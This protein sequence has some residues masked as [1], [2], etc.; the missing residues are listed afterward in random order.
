MMQLTRN[1]WIFTV[2]FAVYSVVFHHLL[3][4]TLDAGR[5]EQI[6]MIATG[7]GVG[8]FLTALLLGAFDSVRASRGVLAFQYNLITF[9]VAVVVW[10]AW[11]TLGLAAVE[12]RSTT[13]LL[14]MGFWGLG[15]FVHYLSSRNTVKGIPKKEIFD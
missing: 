6:W 8:T 4:R 12:E 2:S 11:N 13:Y 15:V 5:Y 10:V 7:Y 3:S 14:G 1:Q 9:A